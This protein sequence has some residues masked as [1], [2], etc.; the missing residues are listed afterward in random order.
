M[1]E[2]YNRY[3]YTNQRYYEFIHNQPEN[4]P[5]PEYDEF[6]IRVIS[7]IREAKT[8]DIVVKE[9]KA[10]TLSLLQHFC[11]GIGDLLSFFC[12]PPSN[13]LNDPSDEEGHNIPF[14]EPFIHL[15]Y[16][17]LIGILNCSELLTVEDNRS[18]E[19]V[20]YEGNAY[21]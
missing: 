7:L 12:N 21:G 4:P 10:N 11:K 3:N 2:N 19:Q 6:G 9:T 14:T 18:K 17:Y 15:I 16:R 8:G 1:R 20:G 13:T 5:L